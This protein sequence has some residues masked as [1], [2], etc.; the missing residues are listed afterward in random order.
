MYNTTLA[1]NRMQSVQLVRL[2]LTFANAT[3]NDGITT[4]H[5]READESTDQDTSK[6]APRFGKNNDARASTR[7]AAGMPNYG[8]PP[9]DGTLQ[10][11][12]MH[13]RGPQYGYGKTNITPEQGVSP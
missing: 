10:C 13:N 3:Q 1:I 9:T 5:A 8:N 12:R 11:T 6:F 4:S 2:T 7:N